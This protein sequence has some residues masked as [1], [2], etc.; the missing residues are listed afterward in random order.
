MKR[1]FLALGLLCAAALN[2]ASAQPLDRAPKVTARLI[3]EGEAA[4]GGVVWVALEEQ[5]R[6]GWHTYW[7]NPGDAGN[8]TTID[9][10]LPARWK[11]GEIVWPRPKRLPVGPLMDYGYEGRL[12][13]LSEV[14]VPADARAGE[15][16]ILKAHADW[17]VC[18]EVCIPEEQALEVPVKI[19]AG[20]IDL[21][22]ARD[23]AARAQ[24]AEDAEEANR[25]ARSYQRAA[26]S[27]RQTLAL[28]ARLRRDLAEAAAATAEAEAAKPKPRPGGAAIAR[29]IGE[30][31]AALLRLAWDEAGRPEGEQETA[32]FAPAAELFAQRRESVART[33]VP[34]W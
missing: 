25:L 17:L 23:F 10:T 19:G 34:R 29:R 7:I 24:A 11:A 9:W 8:P 26:R 15:T 31:R 2:A 33:R 6:P 32:D 27:Y 5:I 4:P 18:K 13:L 3:A 22:L 1:L 14:S 12:W 28:K 16:V 21:K 30:L 20:G